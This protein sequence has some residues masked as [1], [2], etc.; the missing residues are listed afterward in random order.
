MMRV[1]LWKQA[2]NKQKEELE[3][4]MVKKKQKN[5]RTGRATAETQSSKPISA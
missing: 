1:A 4:K 2:W 3:K 5:P